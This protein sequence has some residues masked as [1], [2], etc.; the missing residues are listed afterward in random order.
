MHR[1]S[2][3]GWHVMMRSNIAAVSLDSEAAPRESK[4][5][6]LVVFKPLLQALQGIIP[7]KALFMTQ[8]LC[9]VFVERVLDVSAIFGRVDT[10]HVAR[11]TQM[12]MQARC[13][14]CC[15]PVCAGRIDAHVCLQ[16]AL[17]SWT[18]GLAFAQV[19]RTHHAATLTCCFHDHMWSNL[20]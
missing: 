4:Q 15:F 17:L 14:L 2:I 7:A 20:A 3:Y 16:R 5:L 8:T 13:C 19:T 11:L 12:E 6:D 1:H 9:D 18:R 10:H